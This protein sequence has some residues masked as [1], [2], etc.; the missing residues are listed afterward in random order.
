MLLGQGW[1]AVG[2]RGRPLFVR[3]DHL[4][5][6]RLGSISGRRSERLSGGESRAVEKVWFSMGVRWFAEGL[7]GV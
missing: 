3:C 7:E 4:V 6:C 5:R 2:P 1:A